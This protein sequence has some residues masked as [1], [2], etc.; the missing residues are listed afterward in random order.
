MLDIGL[1]FKPHTPSARR[2]QLPARSYADGQ[3]AVQGL[4]IDHLSRLPAQ[5]GSTPSILMQTAKTL[6][7][8]S[9]YLLALPSTL[10]T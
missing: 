2:A 9:Q 1:S 8:V 10:G 7:K 6:D 3:D 4:P 5:A